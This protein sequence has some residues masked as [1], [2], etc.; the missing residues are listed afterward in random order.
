LNRLL[1]LAR[2]IKITPSHMKLIHT[3]ICL[4]CFS[5]STQSAN[6]TIAL[7][8]ASGDEVANIV[9]GKNSDAFLLGLV[10]AG[11]LGFV[12]ITRLSFPQFA[13]RLNNWSKG[14]SAKPAPQAAMLP[15]DY[16]IVDQ[17]AVA[18][19][20]DSL[21]LALQNS[22]APENDIDLVIKLPAEVFA[23]SGVTQGQTV[24]AVAKPY[25]L[26]LINP[27]TQAAFLLIL[28]EELLREFSLTP[29]AL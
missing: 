14:I 8:V 22:V 10:S 20:P 5:G 18:G 28:R 6:H 12:V 9:G 17:V 26:E 29:V 11:A 2:V 27:H 19:E 7:R 4:L 1:S 16:K 25:G 23:A 3:L 15:G 21:Y 24:T 13:D